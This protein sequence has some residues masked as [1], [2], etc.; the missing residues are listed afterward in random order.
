M[1]DDIDAFFF[2][3]SERDFGEATAEAGAA[4]LERG[5]LN[6]DLSGKT[7]FDYVC[8][9]SEEKLHAGHKLSHRLQGTA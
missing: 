8:K 2:D 7:S 6:S 3:E 4:A 9:R 1:D 5:G